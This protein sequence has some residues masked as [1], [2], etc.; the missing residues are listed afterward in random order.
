[1]PLGTTVEASNT[2][3]VIYI[4]VNDGLP[5]CAYHNISGSDTFEGRSTTMG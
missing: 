5:Y 2:L 1:M 4:G 3:D